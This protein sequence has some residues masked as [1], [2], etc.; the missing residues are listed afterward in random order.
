MFSKLL[1]LLI[2]IAIL[3]V[4]LTCTTQT[5]AQSDFGIDVTQ[6]VNQTDVVEFTMDNCGP[7]KR[8]AHIIHQLEEQ[9]YRIQVVNLSQTKDARY[10]GGGVPQFILCNQQGQVLRKRIGLCSSKELKRF[11]NPN[12]CIS[13]DCRCRPTCHTRSCRSCNCRT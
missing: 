5:Q 6:K 8:M 11:I 12:G 9:G 10:Q 7:C 4:G 13:P 2:A 3:M 1:P